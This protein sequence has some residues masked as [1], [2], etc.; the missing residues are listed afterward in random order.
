MSPF[1]LPI[2]RGSCAKSFVIGSRIVALLI[3]AIVLALWMRTRSWTDSVVWGKRGASFW[4]IDSGSGRLTISRAD[5]A[6][7]NQPAQWSH[8]RVGG[9]RAALMRSGSK[10]ASGRLWYSA[11]E[12]EG[13]VIALPGPNR[14]A[15]SFSCPYSLLL[16]VLLFWPLASLFP[17]VKRQLRRHRE[18]CSSCGYDLRASGEQCP[19]CGARR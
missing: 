10:D 2:R 16:A 11:N 9:R 5:N 19:E 18:Y 1:L 6:W 17:A 7:M 12:F 15:Q 14:F 4:R 13:H 8:V 3:A